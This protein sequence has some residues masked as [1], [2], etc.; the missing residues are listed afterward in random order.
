M[1]VLQLS[2]CQTHLQR[3][4]ERVEGCRLLQVVDALRAQRKIVP[5]LVHRAPHKEQKR[6]DPA[7]A[8][9]PDRAVK[10]EV[11]Q[12]Y[13]RSE[14]QEAGAEVVVKNA[15]GQ[16]GSWD[17]QCNSTR[18][19]HREVSKGTPASTWRLRRLTARI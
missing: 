10:N 5:H 3:T 17:E 1:A 16:P 4:I 12:I 15:A 8:Q 14:D 11:M 19:Q 18:D 9:L 2:M 6:C 7:V 13:Q